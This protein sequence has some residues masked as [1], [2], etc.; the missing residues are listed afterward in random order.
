[1]IEPHKAPKKVAETHGE[2]KGW[3]DW[4]A[5]ELFVAGVEGL[6]TAFSVQLFRVMTG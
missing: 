6:P 3:G 4:T 2:E 5:N 1:M